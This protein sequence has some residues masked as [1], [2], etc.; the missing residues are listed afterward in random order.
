MQLGVSHDHKVIKLLIDNRGKLEAAISTVLPKATNQLDEMAKH[1]FQIQKIQ[2]FIKE[3]APFNIEIPELSNLETLANHELL[4]R[5]MS[6][7]LAS[8]LNAY[9]HSESDIEASL[10]LRR[11]VVIK[12]STF[13]HLYGYDEREHE[14]SVW[15]NIQT[16]IPSDDE[17]LK[18]EEQ[19]IQSLL[20][21]LVA[22]S[23]DK[24]LRASLVHLYN[25]GSHKSNI[26]ETLV[27]VESLDPAKQT[28]EILLL[29]E[30]YKKMEA[31]TKKLM[32]TLALNAHQ[33][34]EASQKEMLDKISKMRQFIEQS[35]TAPEIKDAF[36]QM[37]DKIKNL[38]L[39]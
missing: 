5:F 11:I 38:I 31:F 3:N 18:S 35:N 30:V 28:V 34:R 13:V 16:F 32:N 36:F 22:D 4:I 20:S 15:K 27:S 37:M 23:D 7:D 25:N 19:T 9:L 39:I 8:V 33:Q 14:K 17:E 2:K 1:Y 29:M 24:N 21:K 6:L 12:T 26:E 10:N